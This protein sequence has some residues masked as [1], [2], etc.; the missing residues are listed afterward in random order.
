MKKQ[1]YLIL[2]GLVFTIVSGFI[3][4]NKSRLKVEV[5]GLESSISTNVWVSVFSQDAFLETPL[6]SKSTTSKEGKVYV[7]F[8]LP[9][10]EYAISTYHDTNNNDKLDRH[11]YGKPKEPYGFSNN[12]TPRFGPPK[13]DACKFELGTSAK[14]ISITLID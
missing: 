12:V 11:F 8:D 13:Y 5:S 6:E 9:P 7:E 10:G 14:T 2:L 1:L 3:P 4:T